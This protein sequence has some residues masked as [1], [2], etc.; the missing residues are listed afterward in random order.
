MFI[1]FVVAFVALVGNAVVS[2][3]TVLVIA[4]DMEVFSALAVIAVVEGETDEETTVVASF[5]E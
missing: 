1:I 5:D 2:A 3:L 4:D